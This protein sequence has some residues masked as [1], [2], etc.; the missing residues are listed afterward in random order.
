VMRDPASDAS[1]RACEL[2]RD[3][4]KAHVGI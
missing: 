2:A 3:F 1:R 4:V